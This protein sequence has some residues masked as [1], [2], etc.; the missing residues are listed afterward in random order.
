LQVQP[1]F[2]CCQPTIQHVDQRERIIE[3]PSV[4]PR[5]R[6]GTL[7]GSLVAPVPAQ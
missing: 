4:C 5:I 3:Q 6:L 2:G 1:V 7:A